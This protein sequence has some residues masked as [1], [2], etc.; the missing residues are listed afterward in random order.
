[1]FDGN[2]LRVPVQIPACSPTIVKETSCLESCSQEFPLSPTY[3]YYEQNVS[4][5]LG[6]DSPITPAAKKSL[7]FE[8]RTTTTPAGSTE[9]AI[10]RMKTTSSAKVTPT[11]SALKVTPANNEKS[12]SLSVHAP[13]RQQGKFNIII[14]PK[15]RTVFY[16][17]VVYLI[18]LGYS[19]F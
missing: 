15:L 16:T 8:T 1:M 7:E 17:R 6:I 11:N 4:G 3:E 12:P 14:N 9:A 2:G 13:Q 5:V 18:C 19:R 10:T